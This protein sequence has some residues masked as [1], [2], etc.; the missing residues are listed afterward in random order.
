MYFELAPRN[1]ERIYDMVFKMHRA[2]SPVPPPPLPQEMSQDYLQMQLDAAKAKLADLKRE[3]EA[4]L[5][6]CE[7]QFD[8]IVERN[9]MIASALKARQATET[10]QAKASSGQQMK[11]DYDALFDIVVEQNPM[12][13]SALRG[14]RASATDSERHPGIRKRPSKTKLR[15]QTFLLQTEH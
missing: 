9:P 6:D 15:Q 2:A 11:R 5:A 10:E 1:K 13:A 7:A 8:M 14:V 12:L 3:Q 4:Q